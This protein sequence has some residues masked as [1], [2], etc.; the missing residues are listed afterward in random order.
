MDGVSTH[1]G[2]TDISTHFVLEAFDQTNETFGSNATLG[3]IE[4]FLDVHVNGVS[5][6]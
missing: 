6:F 4:A 1:N 5:I 2:H 3:I